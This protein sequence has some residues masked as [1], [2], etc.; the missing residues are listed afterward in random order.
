[1]IM[2]HVDIMSLDI[3]ELLVSHTAKGITPCVHNQT[4]SQWVNSQEADQSQGIHLNYIR[5]VTVIIECTQTTFACYSSSGR[6]AN[7]LNGSPHKKLVSTLQ[8]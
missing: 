3:Q 6:G 5:S 1:M 8:R 4:I 2:L 7:I